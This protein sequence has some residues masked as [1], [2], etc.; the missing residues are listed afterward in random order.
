MLGFFTPSALTNTYIVA[1]I[2]RDYRPQPEL[3]I[4]SESGLDDASDITDLSIGARR[5]AERE[6]DD[7]DQMA[8]DDDH[9]CFLDF[10]LIF[11][12]TLAFLRRRR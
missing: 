7:R 12:I 4:Y 10:K 11:K 3:D 8:L 6:M 5:R 1:F 2:Y 9:A